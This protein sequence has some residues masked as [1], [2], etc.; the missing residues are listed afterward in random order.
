MWDVRT[1]TSAY[2]VSASDN[3]YFSV[4][5]CFKGGIPMIVLTLMFCI[6]LCSEEAWHFLHV[7]SFL[8]TKMVQI[9]KSHR[10]REKA[11]FLSCK[12]KL[13]ARSSSAVVL[14]YR[15]VSNIRSTLICNKIVDHSDGVGASPV[16][17]APTTSSFSTQ[18]LASRC[19]WNYTGELSKLWKY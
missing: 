14:T 6:V 18:H 15:K 3:K 7:P 17:A 13:M 2:R 5:D 1:R 12:V 9:V 10:R 11:Y 16:G 4:V 19:W 8:D